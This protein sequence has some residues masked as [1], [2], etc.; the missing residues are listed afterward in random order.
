MLHEILLALSG[1]PS[2]LL[3][4]DNPDPNAPP[5][6]V[7]PPERELLAT[8]AHLSDLHVKLQGYTGPI[9]AEHPST[10]CRAVATAMQSV[11]LAA[12]QRKVLEVE[13]TILRRDSSLVGAY[14]IVPLTAVVGEFSEWTRRME[15]LWEIVQFMLKKQQGQT[16]RGAQLIDRLRS[17]LQSG[18]VDIER[19][20]MS[21]VSV[22]E[23]AWLKQVSAWILYGR[24]P[25][26]GG[27]DFFVQKTDGGDQGFVSVPSLLPKFVTPATS[28][29]MLF[30][31]RS[32]NH[33]RV[34]SS[35]ESGLQG[36]DHLS[37]Q[38]KELSALTYPLNTAGFSRAITSIRLT[39]SRTILLKLLPLTKVV[40]ALQ[41]LREF[42]LLGR[43]EFAM[44]L[45]QQADEKLR[46]R[47]KRSDNLAY[48]K[49]EGLGTFAVKEGEVA[50]VLAKTWAAMGLMQGQH[51]DEDE[52]LEIARK[53]L[54][55]NLTKSKPAVP[56][57][58]EAS[59]SRPTTK[60]LATTPFRN[61][62]LSVPVVLTMQIPSPLDMFLT[63]SDLQIYSTINS[64][65][66]S[67]RRAHIRLTEL[68]KIT[69][70]RRHHPAPPGPPAGSTRVG[71][72]KVIL[73]RQRYAA[74]SNALRSAWVTCSASLFFLSETEAYLQ[75][76]VVA[77]LWD[78]FQAWLTTNEKKDASKPPSEVE[79][80]AEDENED[81]CDDIWLA[82]STPAKETAPKPTDS[83]PV[84]DP[85]SLATA[86]RAY[87]RALSTRLLLTFPSYTDPLYN[88]LT[89]TDHLVALV[90]RL[91]TVW[92]S[93]D[94][95]ADAGVVDAFVDLEIEEQEVRAAI[96]DVEKHVKDGIRDVIAALRSLEADPA[97]FADEEEGGEE[98]VLREEGEY[99]PRRV[100]GVERLLMKL[101][102]AGWFGE[103]KD[104]FGFMF[105]EY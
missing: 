27:E 14:N 78:G 63:P 90:Q 19:T 59:V 8:A 28:S 83:G 88:L 100:G 53:L 20:A 39:L 75:T 73:L 79:A 33:V 12:F 11:H 58:L 70:L 6:A 51:A 69:S 22:A 16:C 86:H 26:F 41:V 46:S 89:H 5:T 87:L 52:G 101:D 55:L 71:R 48:E 68:W 35:V 37:S 23:T 29:S 77:G 40:E 44:A 43:G 98:G 66:L 72:S 102:L 2:P 103:K 36:L 45:T 1:H 104:D 64:Y 56:L 61:L 74:R 21:L 32:L 81:D 94:L 57:K 84:H 91:H 9:A 96:R 25:T 93:M 47:W 34:K 7:S 95:E 50:A 24:L 15:W 31:G 60:T 92:T 18:Y 82:Q 54:R 10:I 17:E 42:F 99:V 65:L 13:D 97:A 67:I 49:R 30:I 62:L 85:Q 80:E 76:E 3:R 105:S 4:T 38:L